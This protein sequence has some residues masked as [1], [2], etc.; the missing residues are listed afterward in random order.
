MAYLNPDEPRRS[1]SIVTLTPIVCRVN[2]LPRAGDRECFS[3]FRKLV[4]TAVRRSAADHNL[5]S[6]GEQAH[7]PAATDRL[8]I[9]LELE[10]DEAPPKKAS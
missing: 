9:E 3:V 7:K 8:E 6:L 2:N 4:A 10:P 1:A 5:A